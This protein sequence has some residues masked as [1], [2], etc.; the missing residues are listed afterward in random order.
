MGFDLLQQ[1]LLEFEF[2]GIDGG[3]EPELEFLLWL[4]ELL[5]VQSLNYP[6]P[7][8]DMF[9]VFV[10]VPFFIGLIMSGIPVLV[11]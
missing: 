1:P 2:L 9:L 4:P 8:S 10:V 11:E 3:I 7:G 5:W 6:F